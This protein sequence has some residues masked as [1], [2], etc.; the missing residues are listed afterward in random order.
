MI[1][2]EEKESKKIKALQ[3]QVRGERKAASPSKN[4][5]QNPK[6]KPHET[7]MS[8][9]VLRVVST[10]DFRDFFH[11]PEVPTIYK[12]KSLKVQPQGIGS[13]GRVSVERVSVLLR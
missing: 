5:N 11:Y 4:R 1:P 10:A 7:V 3:L 8:G 2:E 6:H 9:K 12:P 13:K